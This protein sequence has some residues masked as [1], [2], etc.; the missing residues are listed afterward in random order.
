MLHIQEIQAGIEQRLGSYKQLLQAIVDKYNT[1]DEEREYARRAATS[2][3]QGKWSASYYLKDVDF[4]TDWELRVHRNMTEQLRAEL[5]EEVQALQKYA[6]ELER[7][8][9]KAGYDA[10]NALPR[11]QSEPSAQQSTKVRNEAANRLAKLR[12]ASL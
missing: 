11:P 12:R 6:A 2:S 10:T 5:V 1:M 3:P 8:V 9:S 7:R 4:D